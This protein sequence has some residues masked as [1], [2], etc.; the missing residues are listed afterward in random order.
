MG[1]ALAVHTRGPEFRVPR[2][3]AKFDV[4]ASAINPSI[5][6]VETRE[7]PRGPWAS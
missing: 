3:L 2:T 4:A 7:F 1:K 6:A 5:R